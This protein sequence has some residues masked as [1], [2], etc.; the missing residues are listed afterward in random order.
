MT[1]VTPKDFSRSPVQRIAQRLVAEAR[2]QPSLIERYGRDE[3]LPIEHC[4]KPPR[5]DAFPNLTLLSDPSLDVRGYLEEL[6]SLATQSAQQAEDVSLQSH[7]ASKK[8]RRSMFV[9]ASFGALGL[10]VGALGFA[11]MRSSATEL[12]AMRQQVS[13]R[14]NMQRQAQDQ[15]NQIAAAKSTPAPAASDTAEQTKAIPVRTLPLPPLRTEFA[16]KTVVRNSEVWPD[17]RPPLSHRAP[18]TR[19]RNPVVVPVF[20]AQ[21]QRN[22]SA[23]FR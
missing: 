1:E 21:L 12:T 4:W 20:V 9:V 19:P 10:I 18:L 14:E 16:A 11:A 6:V 2:S 3:A 22:I 15:L 23:L 13:T 5:L 7:A 8:M 17:S